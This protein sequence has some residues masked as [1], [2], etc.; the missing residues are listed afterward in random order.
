MLSGLLVRDRVFNACP[1]P[2]KILAIHIV[3]TKAKIADAIAP[4][5]KLASPKYMT[6]ANANPDVRPNSAS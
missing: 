6:A 4:D 2:N 1:L 5:Q 3:T